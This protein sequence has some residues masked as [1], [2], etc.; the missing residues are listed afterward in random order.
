MK[1]WTRKGRKKERVIMSEVPSLYKMPFR[2]GSMLALLIAS[3]F[4][5][6]TYF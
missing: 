5:K 6:M 4:K 1:I 3:T 2:T